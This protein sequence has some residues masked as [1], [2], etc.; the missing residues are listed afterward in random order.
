MDLGIP[1][2]RFKILLESNPLKS[3]VLVRRLA[4]VVEIIAGFFETEF[5]HHM[6]SK[7]KIVN[8]SNFITN[9]CLK[10]IN[11]DGDL[12]TLINM[13]SMLLPGGFGKSSVRTHIN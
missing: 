9:Q 8:I 11:A 5:K 6:F 10:N 3:R 2:L 7:P 13:S 4:A 12:I 1:P